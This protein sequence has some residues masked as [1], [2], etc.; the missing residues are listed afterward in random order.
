MNHFTTRNIS[1]ILKTCLPFF[2]LFGILTYLVKD[3]AFFWDTIQLASRHA[4]WFY[5]NDFRY[6]FLPEE[7]DSG[8][9]PFF[10]MLLAGV[11]KIFGKTLAVSH[12]M[13]LPFLTG[14]IL[15]SQR[16]GAYYLGEKNSVY[17]ILLLAIDPFFASQSIL[18]SPDIILILGWT[19]A[20][21][22]LLSGRRTFLFV[23]TLL[24]AA[25][26]MRG[27]MVVFSLFL[28]D[29]FRQN[30]LQLIKSNFFK[31]LLPY[32]PSGVF[33]ITFLFL[34]YQHTGWIGYHAASPWAP[35]FECV[36]FGGFI[37]NIGILGWRLLDFGRVF[38]WGM[39]IFGFVKLVLN[40]R[41]L[42][43]KIMEIVLLIFIT[44]LVLTP[45]LL[46]HKNL[47]GH[48]YLLPAC[49]AIN[50]LAVA[51][52]FEL[53]LKVLF[54]N[55]LFAVIF[56]GLFTG[57]F[58]IYPK[59]IAQGWDVTLAHLPYYS[60]RSEMIRFLEKEKIPQDSVGAA[61]PMI[62]SMEILE[63]NGR[64]EGFRKKDFENDRYILYSNIY[65]DFS[66][67]ELD[68]LE[69]DFEIEKAFYRNRV[70]MILYKRSEKSE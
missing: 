18:V 37:W 67:D 21:W 65:N 32:M 19:M 61:F 56:L 57:N 24:L 39:I 34:H 4:H 69:T 62:G 66:D 7:I 28:F 33:G 63:L 14:I 50:L 45:S 36:G 49:L 53:Q 13:M 29:L 10:G 54:K 35:S 2:A 23:A 55:I 70:C 47:I 20:L 43:P 17:F 68:R 38:L 22:A 51:V 9:P 48:R 59:H 11:W 1:A 26:S 6:F 8:H 5:E 64:S 41:A 40:R 30:D 44:L 3:H 42:N 16:I 12:F 58:W 52:L 60:L 27:M 15:F 46:I 25:V 31:T